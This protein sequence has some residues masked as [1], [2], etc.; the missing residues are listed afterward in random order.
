MDNYDLGYDDMSERD[1]LNQN[2]KQIKKSLYLRN[3]MKTRAVWNKAKTRRFEKDQEIKFRNALFFYWIIL[4]LFLL[5]SMAFFGLRKNCESCK[6]E[7]KERKK[8]NLNI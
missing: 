7:I 1:F 2:R 8:K 5:T 6:S 3:R 4:K